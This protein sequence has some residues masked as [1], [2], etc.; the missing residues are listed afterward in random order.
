MQCMQCMEGKPAGRG[1]TW[2]A[3]KHVPDFNLGLNPHNFSTLVSFFCYNVNLIFLGVADP[4]LPN[5]P[6]FGLN[7][8]EVHAKF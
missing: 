7:S 8:A 2:R 3:R 4:M 1:G 6:K 5:R